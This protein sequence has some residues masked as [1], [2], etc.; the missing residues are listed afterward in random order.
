M[1]RRSHPSWLPITVFSMGWESITTRL[2]CYLE[3]VEWYILDECKYM[4]YKVLL[5]QQVPVSKLAVET[6][7]PE[8]ILPSSIEQRD[9]YKP[10][11]K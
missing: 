7:M 6:L 9:W 10:Y 11:P 3:R 2:E 5:A 8:I 4:Q 1:Q